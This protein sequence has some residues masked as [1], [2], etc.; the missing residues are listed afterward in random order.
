[1]N[2]EISSL[3]TFHLTCHRAYGASG[4]VPSVG[5]YR[6]RRTLL[7]IPLA[8]VLGVLPVPG[9]RVGAERCHATDPADFNGDGL[10]DLA[11]GAPYATIAA[12]LRAGA[13]GVRYADRRAAVP[14]GAVTWLSQEMAGV[15]EAAEPGDGFGAA[16]AVGDF[17]GDRCGDLAVG[18]PDEVL[19]PRR[20]G[21]DGNGAVQIFLG[22]P[23]RLQAGP[24]ITV[25]TLG[26]TYGTDRFGAALTAADLDR[27]GAADL[28]VGAPGLAGSG[29]VAVFGGGRGRPLT[30][31]AAN[32]NSGSGPGAAARMITQGTGW[33]R[34]R[35]LQTDDFGATLTTGDFDGDGRAEIAIGAPGDGKSAAGS[36]TVVDLTSRSARSV[37]QAGPALAGDPESFDRFGVALAAADF[38]A[39]GHDDLAIGVP[40]E[41]LDALPPSV[42]FGAGAVQVLY[43]PALAERGTMWSR[44]SKGLPGPAGRHDHFGAALAAGNFSGDRVAD[45]AVGVPGGGVVQVLRGRAGPGLSAAANTLVGSA[46]GPDAQFGW[47]LAGRRFGAGR[48]SD[49]LIGVPGAYGFGGGLAV[50][51]FGSRRDRDGRADARIH[52]PGSGLTGYSLPP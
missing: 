36:V 21:A 28:V 7:V 30:A 48:A 5:M 40:G 14:D 9:G 33:V 39:D 43:G 12:R 46:L 2:D 42:D 49:L 47:A 25:R 27:D 4:I 38:D 35:A 13:V 41:D 15:P 52:W 26:R 20:A 44:N 23:E 19:G 51:P 10:A 22:S 34:Q 8:V 16:L 1:M 11:V 24:M 3:L 45:L 50:L 37:S 29:A 17:N 32:A 31:A 6:G 18:V